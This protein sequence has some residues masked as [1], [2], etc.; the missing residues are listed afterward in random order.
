MGRVKRSAILLVKIVATMAIT[1]GL[2][3]AIS[4]LMYERIGTA[5]SRWS[6]FRPSSVRRPTSPSSPRTTG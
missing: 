5:P 4:Y 6:T 1:V 2:A 3:E